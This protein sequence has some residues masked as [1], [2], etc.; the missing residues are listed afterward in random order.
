MKDVK[1]DSKLKVFIDCSEIISYDGEYHCS[2]I[3]MLVG[4]LVAGMH[5]MVYTLKPNS[6]LNNNTLIEDCCKGFTSLFTYI[7]D[8]LYKITVSDSNAKDKCRFMA[9]MYF[10]IN[11]LER[12]DN[13]RTINI[14]KKISKISDREVDL[15]KIK[16]KEDTFDN[17]KSFIETLADVLHLDKLTYDIVVE[18]WAWLYG[19][20]TIFGLE[21]FTSFLTMITDAYVGSYVNNQKTIEKVAGSSMVDITKNLLM[22]CEHVV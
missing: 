16:F 13:D 7:I 2:N 22:V 10:L 11:M 5:N 12:E 3:N 1:T 9:S 18:K 20:G 19:T 8:Y 6:I 14:A 4:Y 15:I 21:L 17:I